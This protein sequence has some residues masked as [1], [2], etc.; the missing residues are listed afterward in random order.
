MAK[1]G[2][3]RAGQRAA[4]PRRLVEQYFPVV[5][6]GYAEHPI[7]PAAALLEEARAENSSQQQTV[8]DNSRG[9]QNYGDNNE[10]TISG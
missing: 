3:A 4:N 2:L 1:E 9:V 7:S 5:L 10:I 6:T 8:T